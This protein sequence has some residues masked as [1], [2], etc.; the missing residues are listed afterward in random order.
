MFSTTW[1]T[2][3]QFLQNITKSFDEEHYACTRLTD[4]PAQGPAGSFQGGDGGEGK[5]G[6]DDGQQLWRYLDQAHCGDL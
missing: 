6:A 5:G 2:L 1:D 4:A 3:L